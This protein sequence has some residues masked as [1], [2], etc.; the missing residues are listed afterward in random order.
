MAS[1]TN[2]STNGAAEQHYLLFIWGGV[3][4]ELHGPYATDEAL[5]AAA[6]AVDTEEHGV[7]RLDVTGTVEVASFGGREITG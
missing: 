4:P 7:F 2:G 3:E 6:R 1:E 5:L